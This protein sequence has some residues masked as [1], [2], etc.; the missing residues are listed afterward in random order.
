MTTSLRHARSI[1]QKLLSSKES[2]RSILSYNS[3]RKDDSICS[4]KELQQKLKQVDKELGRLLEYV[5]TLESKAR[6]DK[7]EEGLKKEGDK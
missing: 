6:R 5:K 4:D 2:I 1:Q 7:R 3:Y